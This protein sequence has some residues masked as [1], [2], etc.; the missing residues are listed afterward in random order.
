VGAPANWVTHLPAWDI[1]VALEQF[2]N[3][4]PSFIPTPLWTGI[5]EVV[6]KQCDAL[7]RVVDGLASDPSRYEQFQSA[8]WLAKSY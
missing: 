7:D 4:K 8:L 6:V 2:P 3:S 1:R 5:Q